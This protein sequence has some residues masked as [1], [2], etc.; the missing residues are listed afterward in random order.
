MGEL[1]KLERLQT[2]I[3][4]KGKQNLVKQNKYFN[5]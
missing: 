4:A 5:I 2:N 1:E 3:K